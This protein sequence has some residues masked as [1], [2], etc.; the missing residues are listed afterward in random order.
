MEEKEI[1]GE[2]KHVHTVSNKEGQNE[3]NKDQS[4]DIHYGGEIQGYEEVKE[5]ERNRTKSGRSS[6]NAL[7]LSTGS[8]Y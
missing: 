3:E 7:C 1:I 2:D 6:R 4:R 8:F 5:E